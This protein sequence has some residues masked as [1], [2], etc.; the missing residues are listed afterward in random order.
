MK[1]SVRLL[2]ITVALLSAC[3]TP[4]SLAPPTPAY[5]WFS[6][7][8]HIAKIKG[9]EYKAAIFIPVKIQALQGNFI[10]QFDLGSDET[11]LY[12]NALKNYFPTRAQLYTH[13]DTTR[14]G[15]SDSG[16]RNY[17]TV[18]LPIAF[19]PAQVARPLFMEGYGDEVPVDSLHTKSPKSV[20]TIGGDFV[21][22]KVLVIDYPQQRMCVLNSVDAYWQAK[23][24]FVTSRVSN[25]RMHIPLTIGRQTHWVLFDTGSSLFSFTSDEQT[26][27]ELAQ[28]G[29]PTDTLTVNSWGKQVSFYASPMQSQVYLGTHQLPP[30]R[31]WF[32]RDQR[33]LAF[34]K[35]AKVEGI[36]GNALFQN[37]VVVLDFKNHRFGVVK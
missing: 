26:W 32:T 31:A 17:G 28:P 11:L 30:A 3:A 7:E 9:K 29:P 24:T 25:N 22:G 23:T 6:F 35:A 33:Q 2:I 4:R 14:S 16:I 15:M 27:R 19:G 12:G 21:A 36:T 1:V 13:L 8:W 10:A 20:G 18:G 37:N 5:P 34:L